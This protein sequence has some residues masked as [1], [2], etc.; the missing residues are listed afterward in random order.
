MGY[1]CALL[2][3]VRQPP[4]HAQ[5]HTVTA[6]A[7]ATGPFPAL[8]SHAS[9][10]QPRHLLDRMV[11]QPD[12]SPSGSQFGV[13]PNGDLMCLGIVDGPSYDTAGVLPTCQAWED[14]VVTAFEPQTN[15]SRQ[16]HSREA[17]APMRIPPRAFLSGDV[18][19]DPARSPVADGE[20]DV[21]TFACEWTD[22]RG[23]CNMEILGDRIWVSH[24]LSHHHHV[25]GHEKSQRACLW[26]G[27]TDTM[28]KGSLARHV[29]SRHLRAGTSC[30]FCSKVY[31]RADVARR[32]TKKCK[33]AN[34]VSAQ[35]NQT[36]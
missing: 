8:P 20:D 3:G 21:D 11:R 1:V 12:G 36:K 9:H 24:H 28:N 26:L 27:C 17:S 14:M 25:V 33:V 22:E 19:V 15:A 18:T 31:S 29:V 7:V 2:N 6:S 10:A 34:G 4:Q 5:L 35:H 16:D 32:H 30:A 23:T 13:G